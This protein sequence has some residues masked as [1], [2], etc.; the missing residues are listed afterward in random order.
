MFNC[1]RVE[2]NEMLD[3]MKSI[4]H[5]KAVVEKLVYFFEEDLGY[6]AASLS[7][8]TIF[9]IIPMLWVTFYILSRL[10]AFAE[11]YSSV[12]EFLVYNLI[13]THTETVTGYLDAFLENSNQM[14]MVGLLSILLASVL[15]YRS[16]QYVVNKIFCTSDN[17][18]WR[19]VKNY[20]ILALLVPVT[21]GGSFYLSS[22]IKLIVGDAG[23]L[24]GVLDVL[25]YV[26]IWFLFFVVFKISPNMKINIRVALF[27]SLIASLVWQ[28]SKSAFVFYVV[29]NQAY[30][31]IYG[32][33]SVL[34]FFLLWIYLSWY[35]LLHGLRMCY[36]LQCR[37]NS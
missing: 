25:S 31:S 30:V 32:S 12:K 13:P 4:V 19:A 2:L 21:L 14:G 18:L 6:F 26:L 36:L 27:S 23:I 7:F 5:V 8:Y 37:V 20:L 24:I 22:Y 16:Y 11:Y 1:L 15:F 17:S 34:L 9:S 35:V 33:F 3:I 28:L 29:A 10:D